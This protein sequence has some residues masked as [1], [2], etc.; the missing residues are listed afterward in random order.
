M[1]CANHFSFSRDQ[2]KRAAKRLKRSS[3]KK[4]RSLVSLK[5]SGRR[6]FGAKPRA[7]PRPD[8]DFGLIELRKETIRRNGGWSFRSPG[9]NGFKRYRIS[10]PLGF[11]LFS[12]LVAKR[13]RLELPRAWTQSGGDVRRDRA[14]NDP[15]L[16]GGAVVS[17]HV[18]V[19][20]S[21]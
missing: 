1:A 11:R 6:R 13:S 20:S 12:D 19:F 17:P 5:R 3:S 14:A 9:E 4:S 21:R 16:C 7:P 8:G 2:P 15:K 18:S 10:S